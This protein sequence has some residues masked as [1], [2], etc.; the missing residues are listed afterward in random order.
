MDIV[1]T[2]LLSAGVGADRIHI[3]RFIRR[4]GTGGGDRR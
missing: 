4:S 3:E 1:E 2:T